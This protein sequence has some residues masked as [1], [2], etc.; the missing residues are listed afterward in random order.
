MFVNRWGSLVKRFA[1]RTMVRTKANSSSAMAVGMLLDLDV[2][3]D[4]GVAVVHVK[5]P[6]SDWNRL[7]VW[8]LSDVILT[9][10][11]GYFCVAFSHAVTV[12]LESP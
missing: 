11:K 2:D 4:A 1:D 6:G 7:P 12:Q 5:Q 9:H 3:L 8:D 10:R